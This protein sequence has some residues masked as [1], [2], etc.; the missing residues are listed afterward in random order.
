VWY[1]VVAPAGTPAAIVGRLERALADAFADGGLGKR[2]ETAGAD[3]APANADSF[4][5]L[6]EADN[7]RWKDIVRRRGLRID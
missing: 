3:P 4:Q 7:T 5:R 6:I 1:G 2:L